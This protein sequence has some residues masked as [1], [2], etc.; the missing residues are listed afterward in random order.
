MNK[1]TKSIQEKIVEP[2]QITKYTM[3]LAYIEDYNNITNRA[4]ITFEDPNYKGP[5]RIENVPANIVGNGI[6]ANTLERGDHVWVTFQ[7]NSPL[8]PK[9]ISKADEDYQLITR[10]K[11]RHDKQNTFMPKILISNNQQE[12]DVSTD[13]INIS[14]PYDDWFSSINEDVNAT[15]I[16]ADPVSELNNKI[17]NIAYYDYGEVGF[18]HPYNKSS[19]HIKNDGSINVFVEDNI[20]IVIDKKTKTI[21]INAK[22]FNVN[23]DNLDIKCNSLTIN[24][25][26]V[27]I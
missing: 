10:E 19:V 9:I 23:S 25:K 11:L 13:N 1:L 3:V 8:M 7:N 26:K 24:G 4:T 17:S 5:S 20:G 16:N 21:S 15:Y 14:S 12:L 27:E 6:Y 2:N 18:T 22:G